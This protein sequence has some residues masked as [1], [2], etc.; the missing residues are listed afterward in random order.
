MKRKRTKKLVWS[1]HLDE[2]VLKAMCFLW[3]SQTRIGRMARNKRTPN[4]KL[5]KE[6]RH[7]IKILD[8]IDELKA[9]YLKTHPVK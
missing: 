8:L 4:E 1:K 2:V 3:N 7:L 5:A 6:T 9:Q